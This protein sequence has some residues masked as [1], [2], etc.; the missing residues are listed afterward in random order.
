[1]PRPGA[2][3]QNLPYLLERQINIFVAIIEM[4]REPD[5]RLGAVVHQD[6]AGHKLAHHFLRVRAI[7]GDGAAALGGVAW[8]VHTPA[9]LQGPGN[10]ALSLADG[11][12]ADAL[13]ADLADDFDSRLAGVKRRN[14]RRAVHKTKRVLAP[15]N[16]PN[17]K[18][19]RPL[20]RHPSRDSR[21]KFGLQ[22][23][24]NVKIGNARPAAEPFE[25]AAHGEIDFERAEIY[26]DG[27]RVLN[28]GAAEQ[29]VGNRHQQSSLV[30]RGQQFFQRHANA[31]LGLDHLHAGAAAALLLIKIDDGGKLHVHQN[32]LVARFAE[33]KT[34]G[35]DGLG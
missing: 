33:F 29:D 14:L 22:V 35:N 30:N 24:T 13:N 21:L 27:A 15:V 5:A 10:Q 4:G 18:V 16:G 19:E 12:F 1:M 20:V 2:R 25:N 23:G 6:I 11:F 3:G 9:T 28:A 31:I 34:R 17:F 26:R 7:H 32:N 8:R